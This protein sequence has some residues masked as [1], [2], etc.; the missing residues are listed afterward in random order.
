[1]IKKNI[2]KKIKRKKRIIDEIIEIEKIDEEDIFLDLHTETENYIAEGIIT[3]NSF[4]HKKSRA[5]GVFM[6]NIVK[7]HIEITILIDCSGSIGKEELVDFVS[8]II[9]IAK[10]YQ[11][12]VKMRILT[13]ETKITEDYEIA[14]GNIENIKN[15]KLVGGG[16]TSHIQPFEFIRE[17]IRD[18]KCVIALTD[19][20]SDLNQIDFDEFPFDKLF[21]ISKDGSDDQLKDKKCQIIHLGENK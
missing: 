14:N 5:T 17:N 8:E 11:S 3:H 10:T 4:P 13:H 16:G 1:M 19:G 21:V 12:R 6:P 7:E 9:G 18:C 20:Y 15:M 2:M